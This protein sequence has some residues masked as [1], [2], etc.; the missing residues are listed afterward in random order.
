MLLYNRKRNTITNEKNRLWDKKCEEVNTHM[1]G[2][3]NIEAWKFIRASAREKLDKVC[4][5]VITFNDWMKNHE[6]LSTEDIQE[7]RIEVEHNINVEAE[8][9]KVIPE[10]VKKTITNLKSSR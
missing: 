8:P 4:I 7:Y 10:T 6:K 3:R 2:R 9:V 1:G 5:Q